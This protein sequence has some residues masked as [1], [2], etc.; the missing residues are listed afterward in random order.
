M[1]AKTVKV[2]IGLPIHV[3]DQ[4]TTY[5]ETERIPTESETGA[6]LIELALRVVNNTLDDSI[7]NRQLLELIL[8]QTN[9]SLLFSKAGLQNGIDIERKDKYYEVYNRLRKEIESSAESATESQ[10]K[11]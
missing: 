1:V 6:K 10:L 3:H 7:T 5:K 11:S 9:K 2:Q 4:F 8:L